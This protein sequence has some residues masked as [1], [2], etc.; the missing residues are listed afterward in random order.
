VVLMMLPWANSSTRWVLCSLIAGTAPGSCGVCESDT[1]TFS[2]VL[3]PKLIFVWC[4]S[5]SS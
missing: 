2:E 5:G 1:L 4:P 3:T